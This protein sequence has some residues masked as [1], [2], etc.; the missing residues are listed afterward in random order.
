MAGVAGR[1]VLVTGAGGFIASEMVRAFADCGE[2]R[3]VLLEL[4]EEKLFQISSEMTARGYGDLCV[5]VLGS[6][7]DRNLLDELLA[8]YRPELILHAAALKHVPLM[9]RNP[10]AAVETNSLGTWEV[11]EAAA[12][13]GVRQTIL[14]STDKAVEPHSIMGASK[15]IAELVM[16]DHAARAPRSL[17]TIVRL[18]NVIGSPGSVAPVFAEQIARGGPLTVTHPQARRYFLTLTE[19]V[20]LLAQAISLQPV[21]ILVPD[22]GAPVLITELARRMMVA[23]GSS[24]RIAI[25]GLRPGD[26]LDESLLATAERHG[27]YATPGL[28]RVIST[29][30][31]DIPQCIAEL[32]AAA[33][34][35]D[36]ARLVGIVQQLVPDYRPGDL[37]RAALSEVTSVQ[38]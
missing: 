1:P 25:T 11:A 33:A 6:V 2:A 35:R 10:L 4:S 5:P 30:F 27:G 21:G 19:V 16:L 13:H 38:P 14:V 36:R 37:I 28:R 32:K 12:A 7:C 17:A 29:V 8:Q 18:A 22:P 3:L 20:Q 23:S 24:L 26:K 15:R 34:A 9:E 31:A